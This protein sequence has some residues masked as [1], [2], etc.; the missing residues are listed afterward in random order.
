MRN[1]RDIRERYL[2]D[3]PAIRLGGLA[4]SLARIESFSDNDGHCDVVEGL[5]DECKHFIE[6]TGAE[7]APETQVLLVDI[8]RELAR[9]HLTWGH[10]WANRNRRRQAAEQAGRWSQEVLVSAGLIPKGH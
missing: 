4:A 6:W 5:I 8:Q 2:R 9:W 1:V 10:I 7:V 3:Q